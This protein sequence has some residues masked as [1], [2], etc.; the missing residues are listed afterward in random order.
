MFLCVLR[1]KPSEIEDPEP[2]ASDTKSAEPNS[3]GRDCFLLQG[4][5][6]KEAS[7]TH[8]I[9]FEASVSS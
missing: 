4:E 7:M 1:P 3:D 8:K 9:R 5:P 2:E 6:G